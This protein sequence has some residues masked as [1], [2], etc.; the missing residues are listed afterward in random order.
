[1]S[2]SILICL[3]F[4]KPLE[5][6]TNFYG[7]STFT[8]LFLDDGFLHRDVNLELPELSL[9]VFFNAQAIPAAGVLTIIT[10]VPRSDI[11][12]LDHPILAD[13]VQLHWTTNAADQP[14]VARLTLAN[15]VCSSLDNGEMCA[16]EETYQGQTVLRYPSTIDSS[17]VIV[18]VRMPGTYQLVSVPIPDD[19][20]PTPEYMEE[21]VA[22]WYAYK[23]CLCA[24]S[25]DFPKGS[26]VRVTRVD[27]PERSVVVTIN[28]YGPDRSIF[29]ERVIDLD[30]VAFEALASLRAGVINVRVEPVHESEIIE[31]STE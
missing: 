29:P 3:V 12:A 22:S 31:S 30:K 14:S 4:V 19:F 5:A 2:A 7:S 10:E 21:G 25:P 8:P 27:D 6:A 11:S 26:Q 16:V 9:A 1:M 17:E 20:H 18:D 15:D 24:A 23:G 28:D 13:S